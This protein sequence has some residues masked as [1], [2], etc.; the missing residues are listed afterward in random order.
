VGL[1]FGNEDRQFLV[2][3]RA[4]PVRA[5]ELATGD[6]AV[7]TIG[8]LLTT[9][10]EWSPDGARLE[11]TAEILGPDGGIKT[12]DPPVPLAF[13]A[14]TGRPLPAAAGRTPEVAPPAVA[15][16]L[17]R[18]RIAEACAKRGIE[19]ALASA[20]GAWIGVRHQ[21]QMVSLWNVPAS[22]EVFNFSAPGDVSAL[23][24]SP[25]GTLFAAGD[26]RGGI[27]VWRT[28]GQILT[29]FQHRQPITRLAFRPDG[30]CLAAQSTDAAVRV[31]LVDSTLLGDRVR[32]KL[33]RRLTSE[34]WD[35]YLPGEPRPQ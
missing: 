11:V 5:Y 13:D 22:E 20:D 33:G 28:N 17:A 21:K 7:F 2:A 18:P 12:A 3:G 16:L 19:G 14:W 1:W 8:P 32:A 25:G 27:T 9:T 34:E 15:A 35:V 29:S 24:F 30:T 4:G 23:A 10:L 31:W 26:A 6:E